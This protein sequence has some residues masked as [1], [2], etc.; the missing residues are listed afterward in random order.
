M[1]F[2]SLSGSLCVYC[3]FHCSHYH[4]HH[5]FDSLFFSLCL[6]LNSNERCRKREAGAAGRALLAPSLTKS[7]LTRVA[8]DIQGNDFQTIFCLFGENG[9][10]LNK[11]MKLRT[12][13]FPMGQSME[14]T[15]ASKQPQRSNLTSEMK[16]MNQTTY[17]IIFVWDVWASIRLLAE[18]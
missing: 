9:L 10:L 16:Y 7:D 5:S 12:S 4:S 15:M 17:A 13:R 2:S 18:D 6:F 11:V 8:A 14:A 3:V 1:K